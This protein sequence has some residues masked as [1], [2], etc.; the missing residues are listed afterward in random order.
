M[1]GERLIIEFA[2]DID[3]SPE[4]VT[5]A[6]RVAVWFSTSYPDRPAGIGNGAVVVQNAHRWH[7]HWTK[8]RAVSVRCVEHLTGEQLRAI[9]QTEE[10]N[11]E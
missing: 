7:V 11:D 10:P 5:T 9:T 1:P 6:G 4:L 2:A 3:G 8:A